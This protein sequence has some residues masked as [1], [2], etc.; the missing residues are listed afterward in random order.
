M[1]L[2][3]NCLFAEVAETY[4]NLRLVTLYHQILM[5]VTL[6]DNWLFAEMTGMYFD[7]R[8]VIEYHNVIILY[9]YLIVEHE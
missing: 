9:Q 2:D 3:D 8:L 4:F 6:D 7:F 5:K 1:T